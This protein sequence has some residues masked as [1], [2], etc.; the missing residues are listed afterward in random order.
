MGRQQ[1]CIRKKT[2]VLPGKGKPLGGRAQK[3]EMARGDVP[4]TWVMTRSLS[5]II[6][7]WDC[8]TKKTARGL[9]ENP[10]C[11]DLGSKKKHSER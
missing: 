5:K 2:A 3:A 11:I 10:P 8:N 7:L 4:D 9:L 1:V 6:Q